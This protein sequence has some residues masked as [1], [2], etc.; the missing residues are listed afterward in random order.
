MNIPKKITPCPI[1]DCTLELRFQSSVEA[2]AVFGIV[3]S[4]FRGEY[5]K[6]QK[7]PILNL[8]E[9]IR[10]GDPKLI[11]QPWYLM[12]GED[13]SLA[14]SPSQL[15]LHK[16]GEYPG[17]STVSERLN[18]MVQTLFKLGIVGEVKRFSLRYINFF[19]FDIFDKVKLIVGINGKS[20]TNNETLVRT[21]FP[22]M[23]YKSLLRIANN[24]IVRIEKKTKQGSIIDIDTSLEMQ[25][26]GF[27]QDSASI[28]E[29]GHSEEKKVFFGLLKDDFLQTLN[30]EY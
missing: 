29:E 23:R 7:M 1:V 12:R 28:I 11:Y 30:P 6:V 20:I 3:Y 18:R 22:G 26:D 24:S 14:V 16:S 4:A 5:P 25:L 17:W 10:L 9:Q 21:I 15:G 27:F 8:P 2:G 13:F 19:N